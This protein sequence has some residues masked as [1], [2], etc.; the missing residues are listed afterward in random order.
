VLC[1]QVPQEEEEEEAIEVCSLLS[2]LGQRTTH[3]ESVTEV[4]VVGW[5][6]KQSDPAILEGGLHADW[7]RWRAPVQLT[8]VVV[9]NSAWIGSHMK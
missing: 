9:S 2:H 8:Q 1:N 4:V 7:V 5:L 6:E 3:W